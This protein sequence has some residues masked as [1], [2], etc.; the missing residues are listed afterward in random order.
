MQDLRGGGAEKALIELLNRTH[1]FQQPPIGFIA[2]LGEI[3]DRILRLGDGGALIGADASGY[4]LID[5][6]ARLHGAPTGCGI[7]VIALDA[8]GGGKAFAVTV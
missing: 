6:V 7:L 8:H 4:R 3:A 5:A 1:A 2:K